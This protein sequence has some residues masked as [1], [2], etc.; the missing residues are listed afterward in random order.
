MPSPMRMGNEGGNNKDF[1]PHLRCS[2]LSL[3][4]FFTQPLRAGLPCDTP[5]ALLGSENS[6]PAESAANPAEPRQIRQNRGKSGRTAAN[7]AEP[8]QIRQNRGRV[9]GSGCTCSTLVRLRQQPV[10]IP[11]L[12]R[13][14]AAKHAAFEF[15]FGLEPIVQIMAW[16]F[17]AFAIDFVCSTPDFLVARRALYRR[18]SRLRRLG[19]GSAGPCSCLS[20]WFQG[21]ARPSFLVSDLYR[22]TEASSKFRRGL[23]G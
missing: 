10:Q 14:R 2:R 3:L 13:L 20:L 22:I 8:R 4:S 17:A 15:A 16:L 18:F 6:N 21:H 23:R 9:R 7:P 11:F 1:V 19:G 5:T 12:A